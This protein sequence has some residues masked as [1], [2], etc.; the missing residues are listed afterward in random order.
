MSERLRA[1]GV[2]GS[3]YRSFERQVD[4][5]LEDVPADRIVSISYSTTRIFTVLL[6]HH[7]LIVIREP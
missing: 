1:I 3:T 7:A 4:K 5:V 2:L 6:Q